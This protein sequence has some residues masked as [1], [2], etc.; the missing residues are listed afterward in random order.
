MRRRG[1]LGFELLDGEAG[2]FDPP[3][4]RQRDV[5]VGADQDG[6]VAEVEAIERAD[7]DLVVGAEDIAGGGRRG[8]CRELLGGGAGH[9]KQRQAASG[10]R[11]SAGYSCGFSFS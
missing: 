7:E 11:G 10:R 3:D 4:Q 2:G 6:L 9:G 5:A 1:E 8:D